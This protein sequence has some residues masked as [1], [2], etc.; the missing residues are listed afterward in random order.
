MILNGDDLI[1]LTP[2]KLHVLCN[3]APEDSVVE[4]STVATFTFD[5][6]ICS[7]TLALKQDDRQATVWICITN[8]DGMYIYSAPII[9]RISTQEDLPA[10]LLWTCK[11]GSTAGFR[12]IT[13]PMFD[14]TSTTTIS[15]LET[16]SDSMITPSLPSLVQLVVLTE[17]LSEARPLMDD[18]PCFELSERAM[19]A[20]YAQSNRD[21]DGSLG[22]LAIGN[23]IG[24]LALYSLSGHTFMQIQDT[25]RT[26]IVPS[27]DG[28]DVLPQVSHLDV[29]F[30]FIFV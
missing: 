29:C 10:T 3:Q 26:I 24:E 27:R 16:A 21:Y 18:P 13:Q 23:M 28:E 7:A 11:V 6:T 9:R 25:L 2:R 17:S 14:Q 19:P 4:Y 8:S 1:Y 20:L 30:S 22:L 12:M 15:W 5:R